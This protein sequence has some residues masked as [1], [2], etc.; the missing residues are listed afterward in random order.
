MVE[1]HEG[2]GRGE[3]EVVVK[4][5]DKGKRMAVQVVEVVIVFV[6]VV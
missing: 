5:V 4:F 2:F 3:K 1:K 6:V